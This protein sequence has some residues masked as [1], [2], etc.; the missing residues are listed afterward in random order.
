MAEIPLDE[1][2]PEFV[3]QVYSFRKKM[4]DSIRLKTLNG[5]PLT[6]DMYATLVSSYIDAVNSGVVPNI[7][8]AWTYICKE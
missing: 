4:M 3:D 7:E 5:K 8:N 1:L 2:R 6:G